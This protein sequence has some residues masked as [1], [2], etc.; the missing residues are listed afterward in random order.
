MRPCPTICQ[1]KQ[2]SEVFA[3]SGISPLQGF[4]LQDFRY[5]MMKHR[6][7]L[8]L[9][10]KRLDV[11]WEAR[12]HESSIGLELVLVHMLNLCDNSD[13]LLVLLPNPVALVA[14]RTQALAMKLLLCMEYMWVADNAKY[15]SRLRFSH[16]LS[17]R[18]NNLTQGTFLCFRIIL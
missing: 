17:L 12:L 3:Y 18:S 7:A 11:L 16:M 15:R 13:S 4:N 8:I 6:W 14:R 9:S 1:T 5:S 2:D 10:R